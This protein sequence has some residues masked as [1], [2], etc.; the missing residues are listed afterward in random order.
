[1]ARD[2]AGDAFGQRYRRHDCAA[3]AQAR[4]TVRKKAA[5]H[6]SRRRIHTGRRAGMKLYPPS[7]RARLTLWYAG[8]LTLIICIFAAGIF[9]FVED[10]LYAGL[11]AQLNRELATIDKVYREEPDELK[12]L[13]SHWG[14][15]L[16]QIDEGGSVRYRTEAWE[17][18]GLARVPQAH[19]SASSPASWRHRTAGAIACRTWSHRPIAS[20][21]RSTKPRCAAR[22]GRSR[23]SW[24]WEFRLRWAWRSSAATFSP[25]ACSRPSVPWPT[26]RG[27]SLRNRLPSGF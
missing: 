23:W 24:R 8:V 14:L 12:D 1:M 16:F 4:R 21:L 9:H 11:D 26:R 17:Q 19:G 20:P 7:V 2:G 13:A 10:R 5:A 6:G 18:D 3:A 15:T 27:K 22:C 25:A